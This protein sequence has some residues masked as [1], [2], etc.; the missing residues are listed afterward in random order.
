M[1]VNRIFRDNII[2]AKVELTKLSL[3]DLEGTLPD[4]IKELQ[5]IQETYPNYLNIELDLQSDCDDYYQYQVYGI[6]NPTT[7]ELNQWNIEQSRSDQQ[8][9]ELRQQQYEQ[10]RKEFDV[11]NH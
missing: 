8:Q 5:H 10:L 7:Q 3:Y 2:L 1:K 9:K 6:R 11:N 4:I